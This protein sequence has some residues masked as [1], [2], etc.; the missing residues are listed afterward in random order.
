VLQTAQRGSRSACAWRAT[1]YPQFR[2]SPEGQKIGL[3]NYYRP[4]DP[5][6]AA[7]GGWAKAQPTHFNDGGVFDQISAEH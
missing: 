2:F 3:Q 5:A 7:A 6:A 1:A 4:R